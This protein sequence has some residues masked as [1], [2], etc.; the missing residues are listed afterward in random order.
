MRRK[1]NF[2]G[3]GSHENDSPILVVAVKKE[4]KAGLMQH[5]R[6]GKGQCFADKTSQALAQG[7]VPA[8]NMGRL[9]TFLADRRMLLLWYHCLVGGPEIGE[10][11]TGAI[12]CWNGIPQ[13]AAGGLTAIPDRIGDYLAGAT[14]EAIQ[15]Q[16]WF[17]FLATK[18]HNSSRSSALDAGS[19]G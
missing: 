7:I 14:T 3:S 18:D 19:V 6:L 16:L 9:P 4:Q 11:V 15:I 2:A 8:F 12:G 10:A 13:A 5:N 17:I 1:S